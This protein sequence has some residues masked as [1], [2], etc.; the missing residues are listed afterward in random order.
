[1]VVAQGVGSSGGGGGASVASTC[2]QPLWVSTMLSHQ[3]EGIDSEA[4]GT[5]EAHRGQPARSCF[6]GWRGHD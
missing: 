2:R 1:M 5:C 3:T 6:S 4:G